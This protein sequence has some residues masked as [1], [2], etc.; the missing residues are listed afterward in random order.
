MRKIL[1]Q[2]VN[3]MKVLKSRKFKALIL[4]VFSSLVFRIIIWNPIKFYYYKNLI[5][6]ERIDE[7]LKHFMQ[8]HYF[9]A[10]SNNEWLVNSNILQYSSFLIYM[11]A[12]LIKIEVVALV[13]KKNFIKSELYGDVKCVLKNESNPLIMYITEPYEIIDIPLMD[14]STVLSKFQCLFDNKNDIFFHLKNITVAL[15]FTSEYKSAAED[16]I[17]NNH[18][19]NSGIETIQFQKPY[20]VDGTISKK[21]GN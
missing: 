6:I 9:K 2:A 13:N 18:N 21:K 15:I 4:L 12:K 3:K 16:S 7:N 14:S 1:K 17:F 11:H 8:K 19:E 5:V 20:Y 10:N